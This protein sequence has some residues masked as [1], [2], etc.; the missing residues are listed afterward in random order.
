MSEADGQTP[1]VPD[2]DPRGDPP[3]GEADGEATV[4]P[5]PRLRGNLPQGEV[6]GE[7]PTAPDL[8]LGGHPLRGGGDGGT[9]AVPD[10][11]LRADPPQVMRLS[12]KALAVLGLVACS[13]IGGSLLYA[14]QP[15][16]KAA[17]EE[18][19]DTGSHAT[20]DMLN[21]VPK[22]YGQIP[23][24]GPPLPGDL[25]RPIVSAQARGVDTPP[26]GVGQRG[27][28]PAREAGAA[29]AA[30]AARQRAQQERDTAR[31][32]KL[33]LGSSA[34]GG[35]VAGYDTAPGVTPLGAGG[36]AGGAAAPTPSVEDD[37]ANKRD[38]LAERRGGSPV[39]A[40]RLSEVPS[41]YILQAGSVI[42]AALI[43]GIRSD[44]PGQITAQV[45]SNVY[46]SPTGR[47]LLIP[48]GARLIGDYDSSI[49]S[50][51]RRVLLAW[52][53]LILPDGRSIALDRQ[54][55]GDPQGFSGLQDKVDEHWGGIARAAILSTIIGVGA[56]VGGS[57]DDE[58][59][60]AIRQGTSD[61]VS[62]A[63]Q[64]IVGRQL[65]V[66]PT[67]TIRPGYPVRLIVTRD[68]VLAP[69][70]MGGR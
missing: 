15:Q 3:R 18:L 63:G 19:Y 59:V 61:T 10:L 52:N 34:T 70:D 26:P 60:R 35:G 29:N 37:Q 69:V 13:A 31:T 14:L 21:G 50:G 20:A 9:P 41:P 64:Q 57:G 16:H 4:A 30:Q 25:G 8:G 68:L 7:V 49:V 66:Q 28:L 53:R 1:A 38:F 5:D 2:P 22:D 17:S 56:Q 23:K 58:L 45:T 11:R 67:L 43:T 39:S 54:P 42:A 48:Q 27:S 32:S 55:G 46:D 62:Q 40:A 65:N 6:D 44:L 12:R 24:L 51:Q 33:F 47:L 36:G